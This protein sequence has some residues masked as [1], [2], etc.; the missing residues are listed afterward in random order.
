MKVLIIYNRIWHYR[1]PIF[2]LLAEKY[3]L[4]VTYSIDKDVDEDEVNFKIKKL[5]GKD[6]LG[7]FF[8]H[9]ESLHDLCEDFDVV[10]GY[11]DMRWL[12]LMKLLF[13][14]KRSYKLILWGI[15]VRASYT[16]S[17]G[18]KTK[19]D[20]IRFYLMRKADALVFYSANPIETYLEQ[21][22]NKE[23][24][25]VANNTVLVHEVNTSLERDSI[26]F[27]GTLYKQ[28]RIYE[29]LDSY[30]EAK[31]KT[32]NVPRLEIIGGGDEYE[33]IATWIIDNKFENDIF[34][35][36]KIFDEKVLCDYF[37]SAIACV[38]PGQSG[39]SVLKS[40][41]YGV[42][43]I[44][45]KNAITGGEIFNI[46]NDISGVLYNDDTELTD[47]IIDI[48]QNKSK[49]LKMGENAKAHY[50][51]YRKPEHMAG[52]LISALEY[53]TSSQFK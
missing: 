38:S 22:F 2:N 40:M 5:P 49:Y 41:G 35:R 17:Y 24:L 27:I 11:S 15:G 46:E 26:V 6:V 52:G 18:E 3:D 25:F 31:S 47:I 10:I 13:K 30:K 43:Y 28:K 34:L 33:A 36:G 23:K 39:L 53:V 37:N 1:V 42:P 50:D 51:N 29:L 14:R 7:Q 44:S 21:G 8:V 4:T 12:S 16:T 19:L 9:E 48:A 20:I 32:Q 45:K